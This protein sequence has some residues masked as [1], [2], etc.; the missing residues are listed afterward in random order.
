MCGPGHAG[1]AQLMRVSVRWLWNK[2]T[3]PQ[4][5]FFCCSV[6]TM[7]QKWSTRE[8]KAEKWTHWEKKHCHLQSRRCHFSL[9]ELTEMLSSTVFMVQKLQTFYPQNDNSRL[10]YA[11]DFELGLKVDPCRGWCS[12]KSVLPYSQQ[13]ALHNFGTD[14][15]ASWNQ[16][17]NDHWGKGESILQ[18]EALTTSLLIL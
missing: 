10:S 17:R 8:W 11:F 2:S 9:L 5:P 7:S 1:A 4:F 6:H 13:R 12:L 3:K 15:K 14:I 18:E 16:T